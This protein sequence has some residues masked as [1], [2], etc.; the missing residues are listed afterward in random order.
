MKIRTLLCATAFSLSPSVAL[1]QGQPEVSDFSQ[2]VI[3]EAS[4]LARGPDPANLIVEA[5]IIKCRPVLAAYIES[6]PKDPLAARQDARKMIR[7]TLTDMARD[8]A[9][10]AVLELRASK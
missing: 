10:V 1:G 2:C 3:K 8:E 4:R 9:L 5:A 6:A 7:D